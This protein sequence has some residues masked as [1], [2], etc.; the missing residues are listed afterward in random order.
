MIGTIRVEYSPV[1]AYD[2]VKV[3]LYFDRYG[4]ISREEYYAGEL[5]L[6]RPDFDFFLKILKKDETYFTSI[7]QVDI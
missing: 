6:Q 1:D 2:C 7:R 3:K 4:H 5:Y